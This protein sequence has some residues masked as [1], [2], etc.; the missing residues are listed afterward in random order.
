LFQN[1]NSQARQ[2]LIEKV[3]TVRSFLTLLIIIL[4]FAGCSH[5]DSSSS[6]NCIAAVV[7]GVEITQQEVE[8]LYRRLGEPKASPE[9]AQNKRRAILA[10]LVRSELL[11]Q[12]AREM[13][14][15][16]ASDFALAMHDARR[17]VLAGV[18]Q[19][20]IESKVL[21]V[22]QEAAKE[23]VHHNPALFADRKLLVYDEVLIPGVDE[24]ASR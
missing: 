14:L 1:R 16:K 6:A 19:K 8:Y 20:E 12:R 9:A 21:P 24:P 3:K 23:V 10:D 11:A 5:Q 15:D 13:K 18:A 17:R 4:S 22:S 2:I 7:N